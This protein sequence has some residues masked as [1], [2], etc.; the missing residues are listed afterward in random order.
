M[1]W[2]SDPPALIHTHTQNA[3]VHA[4]KLPL[5]AH[6]SKECSPPFIA[7]VQTENYLTLYVFSILIQHI[8][9]HT[10]SFAN[11][12]IPIKGILHTSNQFYLNT[13]YF[14]TISKQLKGKY[15]CNVYHVLN[16]GIPN[17]VVV[18]KLKKC[19]RLRRPKTKFL[20]TYGTP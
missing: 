8:N 4:S 12:E 10:F 2:H 7:A 13:M 15:S 18:F 11:H 19:T 6:L 9:T 16:P 20:S 14:Y 1:G 5:M 3:L 17:C